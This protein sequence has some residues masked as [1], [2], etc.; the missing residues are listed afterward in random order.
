VKREGAIQSFMG[1]KGTAIT[2]SAATVDQDAEKTNRLLRKWND[3]GQIV[4]FTTTYHGYNHMVTIQNY[5]KNALIDFPEDNYYEYTLTLLE[6]FPLE[7]KWEAPA[8]PTS[9]VN[10]NKAS[11]DWKSKIT[12]NIWGKGC[13]T[14]VGLLA[15]MGAFGVGRAFED[16]KSWTSDTWKGKF[17]QAMEDMKLS[18]V[19]TQKCLNGFVVSTADGAKADRGAIN[20]WKDDIQVQVGSAVTAL[21]TMKIPNSSDLV[22]G[23]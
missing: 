5:T 9:V 12:K 17:G 20:A 11:K 4:H 2:F 23:M 13:F 19:S 1:N 15:G 7:L 10:L 22:E 18:E 16:A 6:Y 21:R 8:A 3:S 14:G